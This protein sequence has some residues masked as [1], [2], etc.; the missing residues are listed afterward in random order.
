MGCLG[1]GLSLLSNFYIKEPGVREK[2]N[3]SS[4]KKNIVAEFAKKSEKKSEPKAA[5]EDKRSWIQK[6]R[7]SA[8]DV[9]L[10]PTTK[11]VTIA[12]MFRKF[13]DMAITCFIPI[14]ILKTY[15]S[16]KSQYA[17]MSAA[18][19]AILGFTSNIAGGIVS[20]KFEKRS[21][22]TKSLI[23]VIS[24]LLSCPM[25]ALVTGGHG[26]F[27]LAMAGLAA[28]IF[29]SGSYNS[30]AITMMQNSVPS[31]QTGKIIGAYNLY[32]NLAQTASPIVFGFLATSLGAKSNPQ[33]YGKLITLFIT[34]GYSLSSLFFWRAGLHYKKH[35]LKEQEK[36][37]EAENAA[38]N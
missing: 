37:L 6:L 24:G 12:S 32:T 7:D 35:M 34:V 2:F 1:I 38:K 16:F 22:M 31:D 3:I 25:I 10:S 14:F 36:E 9:M 8:W 15:P 30:S 5:D 11:N 20:D 13:G 21:L 33:V 23:C 4:K 19:L 26:N 28:Y 17:M 27:Y 29:V 18:I